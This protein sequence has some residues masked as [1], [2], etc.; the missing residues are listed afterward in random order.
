[1]AVPEHSFPGQAD[2]PIAGRYRLLDLIGQGATAAVYRA[3]DE[4]L[5]REVA[6]KL[7]QAQ[8]GAVGGRERVESEMRLL[9]T[10]N[11]PALVTLYDAGTDTTAPGMPRT[12]LSMELIDGPDLHTRLGR[13]PLP[14]AD[15]ARIGA[16]LA[17]ALDYIHGRG[18][19]HRDIKP[20]NI[21][22][23]G[24]MPGGPA[25]AKLTDFGI[26]RLLEGSRLTATGTTVGTAAY[27]SP[28]QVSGTHLGVESDIYS[29]GLVLLECLTGAVEYPGTGIESAV[30]RMNR[31]PRVPASL[32]PRWGALLTAM[33]AT[34]PSA[35]PTAGE[36]ETAL[37][38]A[39]GSGTPGVLPVTPGQGTQGMP[40]MP[41]RPPRIGASP[42]RTRVLIPSLP[43]DT[44]EYASVAA[45]PG[46]P[47]G[48]Q[49]VRKLLNRVSR[50]AKVFAAG[51]VALAVL[52]LVVVAVLNVQAPSPQ[53]PQPL[54]SIPG[55]LGLHIEQ[56]KRSITP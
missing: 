4:Q 31:P 18:V 14:A 30:A 15:V 6:L 10:F 11:H 28:E 45:A 53:A 50:K 1:M 52:A 20:A 43:G 49:R 54:P 7:F 27:L 44:D 22:L 17:S 38:A 55:D 51:G 29:L 42:G 47:A 40:G 24:S 26:A 5:G 21:L 46:P 35:R 48:G 2:L 41:D 9:A 34:G 12:F 16:E 19:V 33:T 39:A 23:P 25:H 3:R 13:G 56:L 32:G 36:V 37:R 8:P